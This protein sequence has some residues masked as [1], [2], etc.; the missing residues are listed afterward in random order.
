[1]VQPLQQARKERSSHYS[2]IGREGPATTAGKE[3]KVQKLFQG[4]QERTSHYS[5]KCKEAKTLQL[6]R[7]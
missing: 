3:G 7:I 2:M 4:R 6:G 5:R 1:M